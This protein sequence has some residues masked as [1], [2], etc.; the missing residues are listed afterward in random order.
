MKLDNLLTFYRGLKGDGG[1]TTQDWIEVETR[2]SGRPLTSEK[3]VDGTCSTHDRTDLEALWPI[4][5]DVE[6]AWRQKQERD[7]PVK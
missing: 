5:R 4:A 3:F 7:V 6:D 1:C 2:D